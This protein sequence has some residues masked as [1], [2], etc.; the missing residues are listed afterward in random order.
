MVE[1]GKCIHELFEAQADATPNAI[2]VVFEG[3]QLTYRELDERAA[4]LAGELR[5]L[6]VAAET[7]VTICVN[8]SLEMVVGVLGILK[9]GGCYVPLDPAYPAERLAWMI[10]NTTAPVLLTEKDLLLGLPQHQAQVVLLDEPIFET[11]QRIP[12][13][14]GDQLAYVLYTSGSTGRPKGIAMSHRSLVKL[15]EWQAP[16]LQCGHGTRIAQFASLS[17]DISFLEMFSMLCSGGTV[18]LLSDAVRHDP[19]SL[20][21]CLI[22]E[23]IEILFVP[24]V[25]LQQLARV[26]V[27]T[28]TRPRHLCEIV[29]SGEQ[30]YITPAVVR[31]FEILETT[32][33]ANLYGPTETHAATE[34]RPEGPPESWPG[35]APIGRAIVHSEIYLLDENLNQISSGVDGEI[36]IGGHGLAR[37]YLHRPDLTAERFLPDPFSKVPGARMYRTGDS[38]RYLPDGV[39]EFTGRIDHQLKIR[40]FRVEPEEV[41]AE[42]NRHAAIRN[43]VVA[44]W[45]NGNGEQ[46]LAA[47]FVTEADA[48]VSPAALRKYLESKLPAYMI[49]SDFI[50]LDVLPLSPNGKLDRRALPLPSQ[51][52]RALETEFVAPRS[53]LEQQLAEVWTD[54]LGLAEIGVNDNFFELGG[55]SLL[56]ATLLV[57]LRETTGSALNMRLLFESPTIAELAQ[58]ISKENKTE[59]VQL[60]ELVP[61]P[62]NWNKPF[63]LSDMQQAY[64]IG[65][66]GV[67][68]LGHVATHLYL[69]IESATVSVERLETVLQKLVQRHAMLRA[70]ILPDGQQQVLESPS[71]YKI[72]FIDVAGLDASETRRQVD[73]VRQEMSH[74]ILPAHRWPW[75]EVRASRLSSDRLLFHVSYDLLIGDLGSMQTLIGEL[76]VL[77]DDPEASLPELEVSFRDYVLAEAALQ[78][79]PAFK[80]AQA[81]WQER[82][83]TMPPPPE[84]PLARHPGTITEQR[85]T[86]RSGGLDPHAWQALQARARQHNVTP[87][88][89][90]LTAYAEII[91]AWSSGS[92]FTINLPVQN[93][94]PLHSQINGIVGEFSS[95]SLLAVDNSTPAS[96]AARTQVVQKQ[97]WEDLSHR[98]YSGTRV[99]REWS[100]R[101]SG[102]S[103]VMPVV[104]TSALNLESSGWITGAAEPVVYSTLQTSQVWLD[105]QVGEHAGALNFNW[106]AVEGLFPEGMFDAMFDA[107]CRLL[108]RLAAQDAAW[109][110][111]DLEI[112]P[113]VAAADLSV[114]PISQSLLH[115][116]FLDQ[117]RRT[118]QRPAVITTER[119]VSYAEL[120]RFSGAI[121]SKLRREHAGSSRLVAIVMD[122]GW[123]QIAAA[124]GILR[125][126]L[127]YVPIDPQLPES[128]RLGL[129][130]DAGVEVVLTQPWLLQ[131]LNWP[132]QIRVENVPPEDAAGTC[133]NVAQ[134][135]TDLAYVIYTSGSTGFPK[136]VM[137]DHRGAVNTI[138]DINRRFNVTALDRVLG[139]SSLSFDLSVYDIFGTLA[140]GGAIVLPAPDQTRDPSSWVE[141]LQRFD[142]T[143]W[144]T[145]PALMEMLVEYLEHSETIANQLRLVMMSGDWIPVNLPRRIRRFFADAELFSLGGA[146]EAS[147]W[148]ILHRIKDEDSSLPSIPYGRAMTNQSVRV[149]NETLQPRPVWVAGDLFIGG[150]GVALGYWHDE[151]KTRA[152][153]ITHPNGERLYRTGDIGRYL[154]NGEIEFLGRRDLQVKVQGFR[155]ELGEI[156]ATLLQHELVR[157]AV[158]AVAGDTSF[159]KRLVAFLV[160]AEGFDAIADIKGYLKSRL[161]PHMVPAEFNLVDKIPITANGKV[162][163]KALFARIGGDR[164]PEVTPAFALSDNEKVLAAVFAELLA[165][166]SVDTQMNFFD[167][168]MTSLHIVR[169]HNRLRTMLAE[170][171]PIINFFKYPTIKSLAGNLKRAHRGPNGV[172]YAAVEDAPARCLAGSSDIAVIGMSCR[173]PG[174]RNLDEFLENLRK[175]VESLSQ[176]SEEELLA[177]GISPQLLRRPDYV[178]AGSVLEGIDEFDAGFFGIPPREAEMTDPQQRI[179]LETAWEALEDAGCDPQRYLGSI[180][181]FAGANLSTY[182][183]CNFNARFANTM[184]GVPLMLANDK[185]YLATRVSYKLNLRGPSMTVQTACSTSLVAIHVA[186]QNLLSGD[187]GLALAGGITINVPH[188]TGYQYQPGGL[189]SPDGCCRPFDAQAQGTV[190]GN[191]AGVVVLKRLD[192]AKRD[193]DRI[194]AVIKGSAI[195]ND[196]AGKVGFTAPSVDG[197]TEVIATALQRAGVQPDTIGYVETHGTGTLLGDPIEIEA[198]S[199]AFSQ[200]ELRLSSC[201]I[202][203]VKSNVGHLDSAAGVAGFIK[204]A[205]SLQHAELFPSLNYSTPNPQ[206]D[207]GRTP[208]Y[209]NTELRSWS[210]LNEAD[211]RRAGVSSFGLGGTNAHVVL[212]EWCE[213][214]EEASVKETDETYVLPLS[215]RDASALRELA[216]Q[217][218]ER[219]RQTESADE[220][221]DLSY[222]ASVRRAHHRERVAVVG[223]NAAELRAQLESFLCDEPAPGVFS[224]RA[225]S[226]LGVVYVFPGQGAQWWGMGRELAVRYPEYRASLVECDE[227]LWQRTQEWRLLEELERGPEESRLDGEMIELTQC[228][229]FALQVSLARLWGSFGVRAAAVVGHSMGEV[230]AAVAAGVLS[231]AEGVEVIYERS[232]LLQQASGHGAMAA[233]ELGEEEAEAAVAGYGLV[234]VAA[235]NGKR[236]SVVS[237]EREAVRR[238]IGELEARGVMVRELRI[239]GL[240]AHSAQVAGIT[241]ELVRVLGGL[242]GRNSEVRLISTVSGRAVAGEE[243]N[244]SYWGDNVREQVRFRAAMQ[245]VARLGH[246]VYV[247]LSAHPVLGLWIREAVEETQG[248]A[249]TVVAA[250]RRE[251]SEQE[252]TLT[253][254]AELYAAG[255]A[256][257]WEALWSGRAARYVSLP[258]YPW[259]RRRFWVDESKS[260]SQ[261]PANDFDR[262]HHPLLG[263]QITSPLIDDFVYESHFNLAANSLLSDHRVYGV[264]VV[265]ATV[266]LELALAAAMEAF[267]E[268]AVAIEDFVIQDAMILSENDSRTVQ[269]VISPEREDKSSFRVFSRAGTAIENKWSLHASGSLRLGKQANVAH[270][271]FPLVRLQSRI[272]E[273]V[274][275]EV[276]AARTRSSEVEYGPAFQGLREVWSG[277][278]EALGYIKLAEAPDAYRFDPGL[279]DL[280]FQ[281]VEVVRTGDSAGD[282]YLPLSVERLQC[283]A[284]PGQ[285]VWS[286]AYIRPEENSETLAADVVIFD[287]QGNVIAEVEELRFKRATKESLLRG[288]HGNIADWFYE[289]DWKPVKI[290]ET[291]DAA[292]GWLILSDDTD[293]ADELANALRIRG[294]EPIINQN[295]GSSLRGIVYLWS[296][297][298]SPDENTSSNTMMDL[299]RSGCERVLHLLRDVVAAGANDVPRLTIVTRGAQQPASPSSLVQSSLWGLGRTIA[300]EH[301]ELNVSLI[302]LPEEASASDAQR[303]LDELSRPGAGDQVSFRNGERHV[304][305]LTHRRQI[306]LPDQAQLR[307]DATYLITG[308]FGG[309]GVRLVRWMF[310]NGARHF[311][312]VGRTGPS[313]EARSVIDELESQG[314]KVL[315][316]QAD[317]SDVEQLASVLRSASQMPPLRGVIHATLVLD[318][319][320]LL[321]LEWE[322][323]RR[324][325]APKAA[326]VWNLHLLTRETPL[327]FFV[328]FSSV[329]ALLGG[330]GQANYATASTFVDAL[331]HYRRAAGLPAL[332]IN[333]GPWSF[334]GSVSLE[335]IEQNSQLYNG[336]T[337]IP[338]ESALAVFGRLLSTTQPQIGVM[339]FNAAQWGELYPAAGATFLADVIGEDQKRVKSSR[340]RNEIPT[341][342]SA[343]LLK[344]ETSERQ[345]LLGD[346]L[347]GIIARRLGVSAA[348]LDV[349]ST[350][351][352]LGLDSLMM[353][354]IRNRI[355]DDLGLIIPPVK[356]IENPSV[357]QLT[358]AAYERWLELNDPPQVESE[359]DLNELRSRL[360]VLSDEEVDESLRALLATVN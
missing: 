227:L 350:F 266:Y 183:L 328:C 288:W 268:R 159:E 283:F 170:P 205:L 198:L 75:F 89:V 265:P 236:A 229:L 63:P 58:A 80:A 356:F 245:E 114:A 98:H 271:H 90:L 323:F 83:E 358:T 123:E 195:N 256:V 66:S 290:S 212:E 305:R 86:R 231:L 17:F 5:R 188:K 91:N 140:A 214:V 132:D 115:E 326:G 57:R 1:H 254:L 280:C 354:E 41:E 127:A 176:F 181:V 112:V 105:N 243:M 337:N 297:G 352:M 294:G 2:A 278:N 221:R 197:Q 88:V 4:R 272:V 313:A 300:L 69:E 296:T 285:T 15:I 338:V 146:T 277:N 189:A 43:A 309:I 209:V 203:S 330:S 22:E 238:L 250:L 185:D 179:F 320:V 148:S 252:V 318:D 355:V 62:L 99:M 113:A 246:A 210:V 247:E 204:T 106:D 92:Q 160:V 128:R 232:R 192:D 262:F 54:V 84:L 46:R 70:V 202:G 117:S 333:W 145:V 257:N 85:F 220:L 340:S 48:T 317:V 154:P 248:N 47:Y 302:D 129:L 226:E 310:E 321:K 136:G 360:P 282:C 334:A 345:R 16:R 52:S 327:D 81:Y 156:E 346:Y 208:F 311:V 319:G 335:A 134:S 347:Q 25:G 82:L 329:L 168:G 142:V 342:T 55:H 217:Y 102:T 200:A 122:K 7:P 258:T 12:P 126:G 174:A 77:L 336:F 94:L 171:V 166:E 162:D 144:D 45:S 244:A 149:L 292:G 234:S 10:D 120:D 279:L 26:A 35:R 186:C 223:K 213:G 235:V 269:I 201:A 116:L 39:L 76:T 42:L 167:L 276:L 60:P 312:L 180:G 153:F 67:F 239:S 295:A 155:I 199:R 139:L 263:R 230:A 274:P 357:A 8:R 137:I 301:P 273:P 287:E 341:L 93:R 9:A 242:R 164:K 119:E 261:L 104:F 30:L 34:F 56:A 206:I 14:S 152:S 218:V 314:A 44:G 18:V 251:R 224:G 184:P 177:S 351:I 95:L 36:Y 291:S 23:Q 190:F 68:E 157:S 110:T 233:V 349:T 187:C 259:Q 316:G 286:Y 194:I 172:G 53:E 79:L 11:G 225:A 59:A 121:A 216:A 193:N 325:F 249:A 173:F 158:V 31:L 353:L 147:I 275:L 343:A 215:A 228:A 138:L 255:V 64:W 143:I 253:S 240:A 182:L 133:E 237:G 71:P 103:A 118:P 24:F 298:S 131:S 211:K 331:A 111:L 284:Q 78:E 49:P 264:P 108:N 65:R 19:A 196:G 307:D 29:S 322:S 33:L 281:I 73:A 40:G 163:R 96:F 101:H 32:A 289:V 219:L 348:S 151:E 304:A 299:L 21:N 207:F 37:G 324:V 293:F 169:A 339:P 260:E 267:N 27:N 175:G 100:R 130:E 125:A 124:L 344:A 359:P 87:T 28:E 308:A 161:A 178:K 332:S 306:D 303:V 72:R 3:R 38:A 51:L 61:D 135:C 222:S 150:A 107:Y 270:D 165:I 315:V 50:P 141:L 74:Q 191:G 20:W 97:L 6:G 241:E 109:S 13:V